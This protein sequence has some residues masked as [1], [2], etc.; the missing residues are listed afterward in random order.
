MT[1][2]K[3]QSF[4]DVDRSKTILFSQGDPGGP[5]V[6]WQDWQ[7][8]GAFDLVGVVSWGVGCGTLV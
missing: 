2:C 3:L 1:P 5:L 8:S 4:T 6:V 7:D